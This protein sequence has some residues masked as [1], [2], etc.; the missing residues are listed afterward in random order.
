MV[1]KVTGYDNRPVAI[2]R[3]YITMDGKKASVEPNKK[4]MASMP[5]GS[6]VRLGPFTDT[7]GIAEGIETAITCAVC[8][9][10]PTW[11]AVNATMMAKWKPPE[12]VE[13][14]FIFGDNDRSFTGQVAAYRLA[15]NLEREFQGKYK[16]R[17]VIPR[18]IGA[19]WNDMF[20]LLGRDKTREMLDT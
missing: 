7:I 14:V 3:T 4:L 15:W 18:A 8:F 20:S 6:A 10:V 1:A 11:A 12:I 2:H 9:G 5:D 13:K 19:D 16:I 17:V